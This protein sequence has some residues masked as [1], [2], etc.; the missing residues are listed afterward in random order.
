MREHQREIGRRDRADIVS[1]TAKIWLL[2]SALILACS[3]GEGD[4][5]P[6]PDEPNSPRDPV[7]C[8]KVAE[9]QLAACPD[10]GPYD[11]AVFVCER[12]IARAEPIGCGDA[13]QG[14]LACLSTQ[15]LVCDVQNM[16]CDQEEAVY[17][18]CTSSFVA[19]TGC[20]LASDSCPSELPLSLSCLTMAPDGCIR[21]EPSCCRYCCPPLQ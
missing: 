2:A 9:S 3:G 19:R 5:A 15:P 7:S 1:G 20:A 8:E 4:P 6:A 21:Q 11:D 12:E 18:G 13:H 14:F 17:N 10:W 16:G